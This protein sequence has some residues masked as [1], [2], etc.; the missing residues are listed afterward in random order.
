MWMERNFALAANNGLSRP[1]TPG[2]MRV[3]GQTQEQIPASHA[4]GSP[5]EFK[6]SWNFVEV[7]S[8]GQLQWSGE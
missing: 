8:A 5:R 4:H 1:V 7:V 3:K 2:M 6:D